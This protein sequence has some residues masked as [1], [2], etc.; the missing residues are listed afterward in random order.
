LVNVNKTEQN[1]MRQ[2]I[3]Y[4]N[5][6]IYVIRNHINDK[7]YVGSTTQSLSKRW[8]EHKKI[9]RTHNEKQKKLIEAYKSVGVENFY[10]ELVED[11]PC[12]NKEQLT[13]REGYY[14]RQFDSYNNGLNGN[15]AGRS[16]K[17]WLVDNEDERKTYLQQYKKDNEEHLKQYYKDYKS[18]HR[19]RY[20][21]QG[22]EYYRKNR[23]KYNEIIVCECGVEITKGSLL[24]HKKSKKHQ[25][26]LS[27]I[28]NS[29]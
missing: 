12:E 24:R 25:N 18:T 19:E 14:I 13:A 20:S 23:E 29:S 9:I 10:I 26:Y 2:P 3:D 28:T 11:H 1:R 27:S 22:K 4:K 21:K 6:K 16:K 8:G 7:V 5:G 17:Q 15:I